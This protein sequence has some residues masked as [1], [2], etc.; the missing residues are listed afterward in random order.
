MFIYPILIID[1][2]CVAEQAEPVNKAY[3]FKNRVRPAA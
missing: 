2:K 3:T 1:E